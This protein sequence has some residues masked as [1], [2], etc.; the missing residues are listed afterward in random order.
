MA[1]FHSDFQDARDRYREALSLYRKVGDVLGE[2]NVLQRLGDLAQAL[3]DPAV[4]RS[5]YEEA[6]NLY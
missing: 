2:A 5:R 1:L 4:A 3:S 6:L